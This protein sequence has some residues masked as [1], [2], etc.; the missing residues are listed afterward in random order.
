MATRRSISFKIA[1]ALFVAFCASSLTSVTSAYA[2]PGSSGTTAITILGGKPPSSPVIKCPDP[3]PPKIPSEPTEIPPVHTCLEPE[4]A[5]STTTCTAPGQSEG[6]VVV[7]IYNPNNY[8]VAFSAD[9]DS[10]ASPKIAL[11]AESNTNLTFANMSAGSH[12]VEV[13]YSVRHGPLVVAL[14]FVIDECAVVLPAPCECT[15]GNPDIPTEVPPSPPSVPA[16]PV[17][18]PTPVVTPRSP[19]GRVLGD[20]VEKPS[21]SLP[22]TTELPAAL[23]ATGAHNPPLGGLVSILASAITYFI[24]WYVQRRPFFLHLNK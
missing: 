16:P 5:I 17:V 22:A 9:L 10:V 24:V 6:S 20:S 11:E 3:I 19:V 2:A 18:A 7:N 15:G 14:S 12:V 1:V 21:V 23:P 4:I 8:A 13:G